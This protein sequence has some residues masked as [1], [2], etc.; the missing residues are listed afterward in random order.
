MADVKPL[1]P[2]S[3]PSDDK[4]RQILNAASRIF[5]AKGYEGASMS[6]IAQ[7]AGVSKG[8]LYVYFTNKEALFGAAVQ[9]YSRDHAAHIFD[10]L[11]PGIAL[12]EA[13]R[14]CGR[15][16]MELV[17]TPDVQAVY[18]VVIAESHKFPELGRAFFEAGP[19]RN[20]ARLGQFLR[21]RTETGELALDDPDL[22]AS[23]FFELCKSWILVRCQ[24]Q[25]IEA[26]DPARIADVVD[27]AVK[28]FLKAYA[29]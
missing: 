6:D 14:A 10:S 24:L 8:T 19:A 26:P 13:L 12:D 29:T 18:R 21:A 4:R 9:Q 23:Q 5:M 16:Y 11:S 28:V 15:R 17:L 2:E 3:L 25:V 20:I 7:E 27:A 1:R 22:A